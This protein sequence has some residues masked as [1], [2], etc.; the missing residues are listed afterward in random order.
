MLIPM[1][2]TALMKNLGKMTVLGMLDD[3]NI[4]IIRE[5]LTNYK[6]LLGAKLH[7]ISVRV[8]FLMI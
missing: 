8:Y 2:L 6:R 7:P 4:G 1:P 5:K 3:K